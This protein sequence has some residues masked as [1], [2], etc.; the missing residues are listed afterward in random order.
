MDLLVSSGTFYGFGH[1]VGSGERLM[2]EGGW[3]EGVSDCPHPKATPC[4]SQPL[5]RKPEARLQGEEAPPWGACGQ[6]PCQLALLTR[7]AALPLSIR[8]LKERVANLRGKHKQIYDLAVKEVNPQVNW[9]ALVE[10]KLVRPRRQLGGRRVCAGRAFHF[11]GAQPYGGGTV[12]GFFPNDHVG[13]KSE[14]QRGAVPSPGS[15]SRSG[16]DWDPPE[17]ALRPW[18]FGVLSGLGGVAR[19][20]AGRCPSCVHASP[21]EKRDMPLGK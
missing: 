14:A 12:P 7:V 13:K 6:H 3:E 19:L 1:T 5:S 18:L 11:M 4:P 16:R 2:E 9:A 15:H 10:E 17:V 21:W 20:L 8:Q